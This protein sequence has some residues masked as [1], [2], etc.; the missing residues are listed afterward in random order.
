MKTYIEDLVIQA[1]E[2]T[3]FR[4]VLISGKHTQIVVMSIPSKGEIGEEV[5]DESDQIL[6][7]VEGMGEAYINDE[8]I[9]FAK[10]YVFLVNAGTKHNF[11]NTGDSDLKIITTYS[12]PHH[13]E[14][15]MHKTKEEALNERY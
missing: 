14:G 11:V 7:I 10:N 8:K 12:P 3:F 13:P 9:S 15:T 1:Q 5:H 4:H 6:F 2:N